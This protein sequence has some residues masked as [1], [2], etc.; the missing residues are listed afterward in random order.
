MILKKVSRRQQKYEK[1]P[2]M[3]SLKSMCIYHVTYGRWKSE[4]RIRGLELNSG[5]VTRI[6]SGHVTLFAENTNHN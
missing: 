4:T 1:L 3:Q 5:H 6:L 2:S